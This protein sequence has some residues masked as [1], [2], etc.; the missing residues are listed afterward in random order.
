MT[1]TAAALA[2]PRM[3]A[4]ASAVAATTGAAFDEASALTRRLKLP[5]IRRAMAEV[6][7]TARAQR[8][9]PAEVVRAL[10]VQ[11]RAKKQ[12]ATATGIVIETRARFGFTAASGST[13]DGRMRRITQFPKGARS[14]TREWWV[15]NGTGG[16]SGW[17]EPTEPGHGPGGSG[18][19]LRVSPGRR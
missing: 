14:G 13:D 19:R 4:L 17:S 11:Q 1:D 7:P 10:L 5:H 2:R 12:A 8:W 18:A 9:E 3:A 6:V 15:Q 16:R